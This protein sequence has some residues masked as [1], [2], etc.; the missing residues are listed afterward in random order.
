MTNEQLPV[1]LTDKCDIFFEGSLISKERIIK[2]YADF[3][4]ASFSKEHHSVSIALHTGSVCFDVI[5][6]ITAA[7]GCLLLDDTQ[8]SDIIDSLEIGQKVLYGGTR[9][10]IF[11]W[12]GL[13]KQNNIKYI[14]M[15]KIRQDK[16]IGECKDFTRVPYE[17]GKGKII[18]YYG[19]AQTTDGRG[20]KEQKNKRSEFLSYLFGLPAAEAPNISGVSVVVIAERG[21]F[22]RIS[23]GLQIAYGD[24]KRLGLLDLVTASYYSDSGEEHRYPGNAAQNDPVLKITRKV[25]TAREL[26]LDKSGNKTIGLLVSNS[27]SMARGSSEL[28]DLLSRNSLR[29]VHIAAN[30]DSDNAEYIIETQEDAN[31][32]ACTKDYL[33]Q[34]SRPPQEKNDLTVELHR[35]IKNIVQNTISTVIVEGGCSW[36]DF[37]TAKEALYAIR[38]SDWNDYS[39]DRFMIIANSLLNLFTT[40][41][42]PM[43]VLKKVI[44]AGKLL[45]A[46]SSPS[47]KINELWELTNSA[48]SMDEQC[49]YVADVLERLYSTILSECPKC[50]ALVQRLSMA[51]TQKIAVVVPKAYYIDV[52]NADNSLTGKEVCFVTANRFEN[53]E[54]YD[55]I[56][57]VGDFIGKRFDP[58]KCRSASKI[59]VLLY[60]CETYWFKQKKKKAASF[61]HTLNSKLGVIGDDLP[62]NDQIPSSDN[63]EHQDINRFVEDAT[64]LD[65]YIDEISTFDLGK[66]VT[67]V[68]GSAGNALTAEISAV[69]RFVS[70]EQILFTKYYE[71]VV[72]ETVK[73]TV[74]ETSAENLSA[75]DILVFAKRDDNTRNMVDFIYENLQ[76]SGRFN[77]DIL[78]ATER[79]SYWKEALREY[80]KI[81]G[82]SYRDIAKGLQQLGSSLQEMSIRQWL[83]EESHVVGPREEKTMEQIAEFTQDSYL[84]GDTHG[85]FEA[86]RIVRRQRKEILELIGKAITDK[87]SG[88]VPPKGSVFEV[89]YDN[90]ENLSETLELES[91]TLFDEPVTVPINI[92]NKPITDWEV[93]T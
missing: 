26:V 62:D 37:R 85:Y 38:K 54:Q 34:N 9:Q 3:F 22:D 27:E 14:S 63:D 15:M 46:V 43:E 56:I 72:F 61:E 19:D 42:F 87:L 23:K 30:I 78:E 11:L 20:R 65:Q 17:K 81:H 64:D 49:M 75:G 88:H 79:A 93:E 18:P 16:H 90:V 66:F 68:S 83:I 58:L 47:S 40:A 84:L 89:V 52:L 50:N 57:V 71:A 10:S 13:E 92:I 44:D 35:Q 2:N 55:E 25:S 12:N 7:L 5:S 76:T 59:T 21:T 67:K 77:A 6:L 33:L 8:N 32:F 69:G 51:D 24:K 80:R 86:C 45:S 41:V 36:R 48:G 39:K 74:I 4:A 53:S 82:L 91:I 70:G 1:Y 73:G 28:K 31:V 60:E 29:F